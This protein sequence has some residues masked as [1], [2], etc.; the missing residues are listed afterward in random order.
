M[1][2]QPG[3]M[4]R[5]EITR[6][7]TNAAA[8]KTLRRLCA[9]D[10]AIQRIDQHRKAKRPSWEDWI[11]GGKYWHHQMKSHTAARVEPGRSYEVRATLDVLRDLGSVSRFVKVQSA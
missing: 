7:P 10:A 5:I 9:K 11:R 6:Q 1:D 3:S 4:I 2:V 8:E